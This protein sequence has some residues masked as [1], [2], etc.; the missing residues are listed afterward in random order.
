MKLTAWRNQNMSCIGLDCPC[1]RHCNKRRKWKL[2]NKL[3][4][5]AKEMLNCEK[6]MPK[7]KIKAKVNRQMW[8]TNRSDQGGMTRD[9]KTG[10][11]QKKGIICI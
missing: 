4:Q 1:Y 5:E 6:E 2:T 3:Q 8:V 9:E 10:R 7:K 11:Y